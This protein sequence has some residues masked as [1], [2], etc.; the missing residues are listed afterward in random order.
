[1]KV[2]RI[3]C[4]CVSAA[5]L[6]LVASPIPDRPHPRLFLVP[7]VLSTLKTRCATGDLKDTFR[8]RRGAARHYAAQSLM[9]EPGFLPKGPLRGKVFKDIFTEIRPQAAAMADLALT[10]ALVGDVACGTEARRRLLHFTSWDPNGSTCT[11]HNDEPAMSILRRGARAY[12]WTYDLYSPEEHV[13]IESCLVTRAKAVYDVL[14][15]R[16]FHV[17]P[18]DSHLG[19][20]IGFLAEA[21][22]VL[23]PEHPE[24]QAWYDYVERIYREVYPAWG[25]PDGGWNEGPHYWSYYMG[26]GLESLTAMKLATGV[27]LVRTKPFFA[28]TPYYF[29]YQCAPGCTISPFGD[30]A[31]AVGFA[32]ETI[33]WFAALLND[34]V[35]SWFAQSQP[36]G[37]SLLDLCLDAQMP[38]PCPPVELPTTRFFPSVGVVCSHATL[39]SASNDVSFA[40]RASPYGSVSHG[41]QDMNCFTLEAYG[42]PLAIPTGHYNFYGSPHHAKWMRETKA[43]CSITYD[44]G[45]G[46]LRGPQAKGAIRNFTADADWVHF[47]G[48]AT[49]AYGKAFTNVCRDVVRIGADFFAV[50]DRLAAVT[51]HACE[52]WL[53]AVDRMQVD[54]GRGVV[55]I[56][57]P[58]AELAVSFLKPAALTFTQTDAFDP[59]VAHFASARTPNQWHLCAA[60][61][62]SCVTTFVTALCVRRTSGAA[63]PVVRLVETPTACAVEAVYPDG[64]RRVAAFAA[65]PASAGVHEI[66]GVRFKG[67]AGM[68]VFAPD[69]ELLKQKEVGL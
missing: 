9:A 39:L 7:E 31:Q 20:Q 2:A 3:V 25:G 35:L 6:S 4:L 15:R 53:H 66:L 50:R 52:Y 62:A 32:S 55:T 37:R 69:G 17:N 61:P 68:A 40:M 8:R 42:E 43:K 46:Q 51:P 19:R 45:Q 64:S 11:T 28:Q 67:P 1:M 21:C 54:E 65:E 36:R 10:Y 30:G 47:S 44:G 23:A 26:F 63:N 13:R 12:D 59:P 58:K 24:M 34:P 27:D 48:D 38:A 16:K 5:V 14:Q 18:A 60:A 49:A 41:H 57:R 22:I 29:L 33:R 56:A